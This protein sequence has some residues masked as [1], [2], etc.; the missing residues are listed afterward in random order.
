M[1]KVTIED[2]YDDI[3]HGSVS[4]YAASKDVE[5]VPRKMVEMIIEECERRSSGRTKARCEEAQYI[6]EYAE[7]LLEKFEN[8]GET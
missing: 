7:S 8:D 1:S 3:K 5:V 6:R 2:I 4:D